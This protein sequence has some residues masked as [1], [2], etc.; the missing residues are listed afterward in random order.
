MIRVRQVKIP[1]TLDNDDFIYK[2]LSKMLKCKI[3]D[4]RIIK[5]TVRMRKNRSSDLSRGASPVRY[6]LPRPSGLK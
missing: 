1:I 5:K 4:Y 6:L 2:K 3:T